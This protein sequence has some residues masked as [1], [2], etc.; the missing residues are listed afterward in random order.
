MI[1]SY[2]LVW[3]LLANRAEHYSDTQFNRQ[4]DFLENRGLLNEEMPLLQQ[5]KVILKNQNS[6]KIGLGRLGTDEYIDGV[7]VHFGDAMLTPDMLRRLCANL[8][9]F[10]RL[11]DLL[12]EHPEAKPTELRKLA[13]EIGIAGIEASKKVTYKTDVPL[14]MTQATPIEL[15]KAV[16]D[17]QFAPRPDYYETKEGLK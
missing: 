4:T 6:S 13:Y 5:V 16:A 9:H 14:D 1:A 15:S 3:D 2:P 11:V 10:P 17:N 12:A 7:F 8:I